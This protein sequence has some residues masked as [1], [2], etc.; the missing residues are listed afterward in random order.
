MTLRLLTLSCWATLACQGEGS[1]PPPK[2]AGPEAGA[3]VA[4]IDADL[5]APPAEDG[6]PAPPVEDAAPAEAQ[7]EALGAIPA[8]QAVIDRDRYLQRRGQH[9]V[10]YG[11]VGPE[12]LVTPSDAGDGSAG[13]SVPMTGDAAPPRGAPGAIG[14]GTFW[15][16]DDS[17]GHGSLAVRVKWPPRGKPPAL[18]DRVAAGGAWAVGDD[19]RWIWQADAWSALPP[20]PPSPF[21]EPPAPPHHIV[22]SGAPPSGWKPVAAAKD[23]GIIAFQIVGAPPASEGEGWKVA[24]EL[25]DAP[26]AILFLPGERASYGGH[27]LRTADEKWQLKRG[28]TY[29]VRIG[30]VRRRVPDQPPTINARTAPVAW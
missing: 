12:I 25:G 16:V 17:E 1:S 20:S 23:D 10:I 30:K 29:W 28:T 5:L 13:A 15:L 11:V 3:P 8:W 22:G 14:T 7:I 4:T 18:G 21:P 26:A 2:P 9:G 6:A 19:R 27:D 24:N